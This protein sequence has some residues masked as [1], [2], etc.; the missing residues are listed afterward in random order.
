M[1]RKESLYEIPVFYNVS[2]LTFCAITGSF[3]CQWTFNELKYISLDPS[4]FV[5]WGVIHYLFPISK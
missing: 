4:K 3:A 5:Y 1:L 2:L